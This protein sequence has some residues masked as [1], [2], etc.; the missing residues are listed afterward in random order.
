MVEQELITAL[1]ELISLVLPGA[2]DLAEIQR[3]VE[4]LKGDYPKLGN[5]LEYTFDAAEHVPGK[6]F[7]NRVDIKAWTESRERQS[8]Y[9]LHV[10]L[11]N[12][13]ADT[14]KIEGFW[15]TIQGAG[16][17]QSVIKTLEFIATQK[18]K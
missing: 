4:K 11:Q 12:F 9:A 10:F 7:S 14:S 15:N 16:D 2:S 5:L 6:L 8:L 18:R 1:I 3:R 13:A 17:V